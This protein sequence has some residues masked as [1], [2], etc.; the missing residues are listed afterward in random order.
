MTSVVEALT[1][2]TP[3]T[4]GSAPLDIRGQFSAGPA[5][6]VVGTPSSEDSQLGDKIL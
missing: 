6:D 3:L 4:L 1:A 2:R 5:P